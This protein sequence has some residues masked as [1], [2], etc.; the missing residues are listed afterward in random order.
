LNFEIDMLRRVL[1]AVIYVAGLCVVLYV[2]YFVPYVNPEDDQSMI[3]INN[4]GLL[5]TGMAFI[6]VASVLWAVSF[7]SEGSRNGERLG[8]E[9]V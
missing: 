1:A 4:W 7:S 8:D 5:V 9:K 2:A 6:L 3:A